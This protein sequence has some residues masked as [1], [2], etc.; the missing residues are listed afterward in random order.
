M[1]KELQQFDTSTRTWLSEAQFDRTL[2]NSLVTVIERTVQQTKNLTENELEDYGYREYEKLQKAH[3][4]KL[5]ERL[6][7]AGRM[8]EG[9]DKK[10]PGLKNLLRSKGIGDSAIVANML[11]GKRSGI[12]FAGKGGDQAD[13]PAPAAPPREAAEITVEQD[14]IVGAKR[15]RRPIPPIIFE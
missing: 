14:S 12:G 6:H 15:Q 9:L 1:T 4:D 3:G 7:Q 10:Q 8:V 2:G 5:D 11:S 13:P